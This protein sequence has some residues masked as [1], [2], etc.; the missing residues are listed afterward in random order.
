MEA[1]Q[2]LIGQIGVFIICA[3]TIIHFRP[4]EVYGKYLRLL[5][6]GMVLVQVFGPVYGLFFG[7]E[8]KSMEDMIQ[9]F[10]EGF[11]ASMREAEQKG[12]VSEQQLEHMSLE[13][14]RELIEQ[15]AVEETQTEPP[16]QPASLGKSESQEQAEHR[17]QAPE[18]SESPQADIAEVE[19][20]IPPITVTE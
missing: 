18:Q 10:Q 16:G 4:K 7:Q 8:G 12:A 20:V 9:S 6:G 13:M 5:L 19:I 1:F 15:G 3:Q 11:E 2:K 17:E 14:L